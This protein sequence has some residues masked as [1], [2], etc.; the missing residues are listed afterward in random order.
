MKEL[1]LTID[2]S[3][4]PRHP[5]VVEQELRDGL[6]FV[7]A[8]T[9]L[10]LLKVVHGYGSTGRGGSTK[11]TVKNWAF[12]ERNRLQAVISGETYS[13]FDETTR[14]MRADVGPYEDADL[15]AGNKGIT[16]LWVK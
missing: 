4:P 8:S 14:R 12:R 3:H 1:V 6:S 15:D 16:I 13:L 9:V 5:D 2:V 10:R 11:A 7:R